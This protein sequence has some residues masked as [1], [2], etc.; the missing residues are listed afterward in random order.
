MVER[1]RYPLN[2]S[3]S[4]KQFI[5]QNSGFFKF[6]G[7]GIWDGDIEAL[8]LEHVA[9]FLVFQYD[10]IHCWVRQNRFHFQISFNLN[11]SMRTI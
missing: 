2:G 8:E 7:Q 1:E 4:F 3:G 5:K 11:I 9:L 10:K 6:V